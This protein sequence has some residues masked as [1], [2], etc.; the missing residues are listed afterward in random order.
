[1]QVLRVSKP[2]FTL[3]ARRYGNYGYYAVAKLLW[4]TLFRSMSV[5]FAFVSFLV[6]SLFPLAKL[7]GPPHSAKRRK[8]KNRNE[9]KRKENK[10]KQKKRKEKKR[11][12][13][14]RKE[15]TMPLCVYIEKLKVVTVPILFSVGMPWLCCQADKPS[16]CCTSC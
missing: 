1:M 5:S 10:T 12:E 16:L 8:E 3:T 13:K 11:K 15:N 14:K 9:K 6:V 4:L 7:V 2:S